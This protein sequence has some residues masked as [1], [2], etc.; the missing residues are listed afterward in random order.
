MCKYI[1]VFANYLR[2]PQRNLVD[3]VT[4]NKADQGA[5]K[6]AEVPMLVKST[7]QKDEPAA[8][9][10]NPVSIML[11]I[12]R[13]AYLEEILFGKVGSKERYE[14]PSMIE[15]AQRMETEALVEY[16]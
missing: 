6:I 1:E 12:A 16:L 10:C 15:L 7:G 13:S 4:L 3:I 8:S 2:A 5:L 14:I 11:E 9:C